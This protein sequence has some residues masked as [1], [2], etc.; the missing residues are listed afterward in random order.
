LTNA[1]T[2]SA[3]TRFLWPE[4]RTRP[5]ST[6]SSRASL[7][8]DGL[9]C[10]SP[11][12]VGAAETDEPAARGSVDGARAAPDAGGEAD[13]GAR[14]ELEA[15]AAAARDSAERSTVASG[16]AVP[17]G[18]ADD[19]LPA[20]AVDA[21]APADAPPAAADAPPTAAD[22][23]P[24]DAASALGRSTATGS[25]AFTRDPFLTFTSST[26]PA[27]GAGTSMLAFSVSSVTRPCSGTTSSPAFTS[28]SITSTSAKSP[29]SGTTIVCGAAAGVVF[30]WRTVLSS[31]AR[32]TFG[33][34]TVMSSGSRTTFG[35][36]TV[37]SPAERGV[38][39]WRIVLS[40]AG[41]ASGAVPPRASSL[42]VAS[43]RIRSPFDTRSPTLTL[44][45]SI[46]PAAGDGTSIVAFSVSSVMRPC[47]GA[48]SS[49]GFTRI[50]M[51]STSAKSPRS[52]TTTSTGATEEKRSYTATGLRFS[53]S[54]PS[55]AIASPTVLR[56][57]PPSSA[58]ALRA[59]TAIDLRS[60]SKCERSASRPSLRP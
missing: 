31:G 33:C 9:A 60:T 30:G 22:S 40:S 25:P 27:S 57:T 54:M 46:R 29:R 43:D 32:T 14:P 3:V 37:V 44:S 2:S 52:G 42:C 45:S 26:V 36:S 53:G 39:G 20:G 23:P 8:T 47:S 6:P 18:A 16:A 50:S 10:A 7:R 59:A 21:P 5:S 58:S 48:T 24:A 38:F 1:L 4:P 56:S 34:S 15:A 17:E 49:P 12:E 35:C 55:C 51:I 11:N 13:A 41:G 19:G 28:T